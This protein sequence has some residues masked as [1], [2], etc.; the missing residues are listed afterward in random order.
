MNTWRRSCVLRIH[1]QPHLAVIVR[2]GLRNDL[3]RGAFLLWFLRDVAVTKIFPEGTVA[4]DGL[5]R[6]QAFGRQP[7]HSS[8]FR[9]TIGYVRPASFILVFGPE[10]ILGFVTDS[11]ELLFDTICN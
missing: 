11:V 5:E 4:G 8:L 2:F 6:V 7:R 3:S 1:A 10:E 9:I